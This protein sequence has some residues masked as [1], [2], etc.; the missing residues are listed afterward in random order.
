MHLCPSPARRALLTLV[1]G[2]ALLA[3]YATQAVRAA[4]AWPSRNIRLVIPYAPGNAG[5]VTFRLIQADLEKRLGARFYI[6]NKSGASGNIGAED[7]VRAAPDGYTLL[8]GATNNF[9]MNQYLTKGLRYDPLK[10]LAPITKVNLAPSVVVVNT[11]LPVNSLSEL[12]AYA[13][14]NPGKL[15]FGTP[16]N[17]TPPHLTGVLY[18]QMTQT[19]MVHVPFR[20]APPAVQA[21]LANDVQIFFASAGIS[22]VAGHLAAGKLKA[23]AV[24]D[25]QRL[26]A[27]PSVPTTAEQGLPDLRTGNWWGLAAP[28]G[29][30]PAILEKIAAA[31]KASVSS[32]EIVARFNE[33]G[34]SGVGNTPAEFAAQNAREAAVWQAT[35]SKANIQVD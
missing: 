17:G 31:V 21:L 27:L 30:D 11:S 19:E 33:L 2:A 25:T 1:C 5:D 29:T 16:G 20:G 15:N 24:A 10:D 34:L 32:P 23:L 4:D 14:A 8:L 9:V 26:A 35:I 12:T 18:A 7:V 13:K 22:T 3:G 6:D 28:V